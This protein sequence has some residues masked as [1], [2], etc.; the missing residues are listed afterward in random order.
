[1][2]EPK[3]EIKINSTKILNSEESFSFVSKFLKSS[4]FLQKLFECP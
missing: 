3:E 1:M 4:L 2:E